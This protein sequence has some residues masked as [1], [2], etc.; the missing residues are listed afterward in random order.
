[1]SKS[2]KKSRAGRNPTS[3]EVQLRSLVTRLK[4]QAEKLQGAKEALE[5][6]ASSVLEALW[7]EHQEL[8]VVVDTMDKRIARLEALAGIEGETHEHTETMETTTDGTGGIPEDGAGSEGEVHSPETAG[9]G[10]A[11]RGAGSQEGAV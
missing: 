6:E 4:E 3:T 11:K 8:V 9:S 1:M 10:A 7:N 5:G 2:K